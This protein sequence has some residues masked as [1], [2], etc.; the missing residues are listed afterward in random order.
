[1]NQLAVVSSQ[2]PSALRLREPFALAPADLRACRGLIQRHSRSFYVSSLLL[3]K[4][5][6]QQ[7]WAL[8]A[9]CRHADDTVDG[10]NDG[11]GTVAA[12]A[13]SSPRVLL[14]RVDSLRS[15]LHT[16][17]AEDAALL[18]APE[19]FI[20]RAFAAVVAHTGLPQGVPEQLLRGM[21]MDA[22]GQQYGSWDE[23]L[24]YCFNVASTVGLMM[25]YV[26]GH[27]LPA[28]AA[29]RAAKAE[30]YLRACDL[31]VAMQLTNIARDVGEDARRGRV[32][33]PDE[34]L[35][36]HGLRTDVIL[37]LAERG[38]P[39][40]PS[41]RRAVAELLER[42]EQHYAAARK[43]IP[44]LRPEGQ[45]AIRAAESIYR[46]I[47]ERLRK[48]GCD[49]LLGRARVSG[50]G[51]LVRMLRVWLLGLLP[52]ARQLPTQRT[53]GPADELLLRLCRGA[54]V[55]VD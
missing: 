42:A 18:A 32:Y 1:M 29:E 20:D 9:F 3:P 13:E 50:F 12:D 37:K 31:G 41:L 25:T 7:A 34:L 22:K 15:R 49:P 36:R 14:A 33:L 48:T 6:R 46:G 17:Y 21:E 16:V 39:S 2:Q 40:P 44:M 38:G 23:L 54:G 5:K 47:G 45:L 4:Q 52:S 28:D 11:R 26:L 35:S 27:R 53:Q 10:E 24:L 43:G 51:K 8:Y 55:D 19:R 30:V